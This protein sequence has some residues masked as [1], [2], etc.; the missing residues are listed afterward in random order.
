MPDLIN[1][2]SMLGGGV[3]GAGTC[4]WNPYVS[5]IDSVGQTLDMQFD[6]GAMGACA[7]MVRVKCGSPSIRVKPS[8]ISPEGFLVYFEEYDV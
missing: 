6:G 5:D 1:R 7:R 8:S 4:P 2:Y 3:Q